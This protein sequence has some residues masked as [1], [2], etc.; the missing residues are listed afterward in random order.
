MLSGGTITKKTQKPQICSSVLCLLIQLI[1]LPWIYSGG[2][3]LQ[4]K[5]NSARKERKIYC[6]CSASIKEGDKINAIYHSS[7]DTWVT[8]QT[9]G[10]NFGSSVNSRRLFRNLERFQTDHNLWG[11]IKLLKQRFAQANCP[12]PCF[13]FLEEEIKWRSLGYASSDKE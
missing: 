3:Q 7:K 11:T 5:T 9:L 13:L 10:P 4:L 6:Y 1:A 8:L 12:K 2:T